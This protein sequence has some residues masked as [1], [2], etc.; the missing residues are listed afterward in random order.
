METKQPDGTREATLSPATLF[1]GQGRFRDGQRFTGSHTGGGSGAETRA[2][3]PPF[4]TL[5]ILPPAPRKWG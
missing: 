1:H 5:R 3:G 4:Q 2:W